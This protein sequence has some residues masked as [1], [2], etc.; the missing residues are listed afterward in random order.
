MAVFQEVGDKQ[1]LSKGPR[2]YDR[3]KFSGGA[4]QLIGDHVPMSEKPVAMQ[5]DKKGH[6]GGA[7]QEVGD[8]ISLS[9]KPQKGWNSAS[10]PMS[11]RA[12]IQSKM[13]GSAGRERIT[14]YKKKKA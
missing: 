10:T 3:S 8:R 9:R 14:K 4:H 6:H 11:D 5:E 7:F 2:N 12:W 13:S 1:K